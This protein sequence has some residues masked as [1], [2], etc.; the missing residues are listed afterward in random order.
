MTDFLHR[1]VLAVLPPLYVGFSKLWF[2]TYR[3]TIR[4]EHYIDEAQQ[5][6][7]VIVPFW[8][9]TIF[10]VFHHLKQYPGVALISSSRYGE[11]IARIE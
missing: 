9:Y 2:S 4:D 6:G 5:Q 11:Y 10:Y 1:I 3:V 8:H 7:A